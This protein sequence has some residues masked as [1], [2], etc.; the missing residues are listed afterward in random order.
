MSLSGVVSST[1]MHQTDPTSGV[2]SFQ[3]FWQGFNKLLTSLQSGDVDG[4]NRAYSTLQQLLPNSSGSLQ[5]QNLQNGGGQNSF[6]TDF[7]ALGKALDS[8]DL[9]AAQSAFQK[10]QQ[11]M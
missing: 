8:G 11:D 2:N 1:S 3:K 10:L 4:A 5:T 6:A 7:A 9:S